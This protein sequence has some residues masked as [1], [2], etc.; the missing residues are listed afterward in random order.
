MQDKASS[1]ADPYRQPYDHKAVRSQFGRHL[2]AA[3]RRAGLSQQKLSAKAEVS[4][5]EI[6]RCEHGAVCPRLDTALRL[7]AAL[8]H[9]PGKFLRAVAVAV[10]SSG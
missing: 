4:R 1:A 6:S 9:D 3:R 2:F 5:D 7:A 8:H 10:E